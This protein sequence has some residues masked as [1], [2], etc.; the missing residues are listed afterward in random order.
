[1]S[2]SDGA[3]KIKGRKSEGKKQ[4]AHTKTAH[5]VF[6]TIMYKLSESG[7]GIFPKYGPT[8]RKP[9]RVSRPLVLRLI[10][11]TLSRS[12]QTFTLFYF[13]HCFCPLKNPNYIY[14]FFKIWYRKIRRKS[15]IP[16]CPS[17][18]CSVDKGDIWST[19]YLNICV[20]NYAC[21][22]C[23]IFVSRLICGF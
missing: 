13:F 18:T 3:V 5:F 20:Y 23:Y 15:T 6:S 2:S 17:L 10:V 12:P 19:V 22:F 1:M 11:S 7:I 14:I 8:D 21:M 16:A 9:L 4:T